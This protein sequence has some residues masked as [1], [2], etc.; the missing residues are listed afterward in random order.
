MCFTYG[1]YFIS[2]IKRVD[3]N[4]RITGIT[5]HRPKSK[6][7]PAMKMA[8]A[9]HANSVLLYNE[10]K[11]I[12]KKVFYV[13]NGVDSNLFYPYTP[14][15]ENEE[16]V[17]GHVGKK[18]PMKG[19]IDYI[20]PAVNLSGV[21][22]FSHYN[23]YK[24]RLSHTRMVDVHQ[25]YDVFICASKEDGTPCP[26]LEAAACGRPIISNKIGNM[27]E[28][29]ENYKTGILLDKKDVDLYI[30]AI[31]WCKDNPDKVVEMG[32]NI[33]EKIQQE[34]TWELMAKNYLYMFDSI[35]KI[36]REP[37]LYE[38]PAKYHI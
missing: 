20:E 13:P 12:H 11:R 2:K 16:M 32:K 4:K 1:Y 10:L 22:Y 37:E 8:H 24:T 34:W 38:N 30:D 25:N 27:P 3:K 33:R 14:L 28:L 29:I 21:Q 9:T 36:K 5:A 6:I 35:L 23:N 7:E 18:S 15:L 26:A 17:F 19:Q 31:K